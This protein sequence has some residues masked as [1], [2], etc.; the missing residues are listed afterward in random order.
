MPNYIHLIWQ[1]QD[2]HKKAKVQQSFL[3]YTAQQMKF[4][5]AKTVGFPELRPVDLE[6][7]LKLLT[8]NFTHYAK[9][10]VQREPNIG[11]Y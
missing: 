4:M 6:L 1:I 7:I 10:E 11:C 8:L 5:L 9:E 2:G 3:K